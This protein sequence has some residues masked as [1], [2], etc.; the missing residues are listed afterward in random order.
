MVAEE[1]LPLPARD[2]FPVLAPAYYWA[3][4]GSARIH[5]LK[6]F[7]LRVDEDE[8]LAA[9]HE[10]RLRWLASAGVNLLFLSY[11]WGLPPELERRD[12]LDFE[13]AAARA[14]RL[15]LEVAAYVQPS[16]AADV[17]SYASSGWWALTP[18]GQRIPYYN[19]RYF[20]CLSNP[21]WRQTV[22]ERA[23]DAVFRGADAVF[24]DNC[25]FGG[26][27]IPL[28]ADTTG[29]A[30]CACLRCQAAFK[31]WLSREGLPASSI[32]RVLRAAANPAV[33]HYFRWRA[34]VVTSLLRETRQAVHA[35]RP[36]AVV[37]TNTFGAASVDAFAMFGV[38]M[39]SVAREVDWLFVENLQ[40]PR[41][42]AGRLTQNAGTFK[43]L[44]ALK[45]SAPALS[46]SYERG[47]GVDPVPPPRAF[48]RIAAE[49]FAAG[50][51]PVLRAGEYVTAGAWTHLRPVHHD[52]QLR[53]WRSMTDFV[54]ANPALFANRR[55]AAG[56][57]LVLPA[58]AQLARG[59]VAEVMA[60]AEALVAA[61][62]PFRVVQDGQRLDGV[63]VA[64]GPTGGRPPGWDGEWLAYAQL[65]PPRASAP[66]ERLLAFVEP[67]LRRVGPALLRAYY[68]QRLVRKAADR[69]D[70]LVRVA[71]VGQSRV[72]PLPLPMRRRLRAA[73]PVRA[74][75]DSPVYADLWQCPA[76]LALHLVNY[77]D[78]PARVR[79]AQPRLDAARLLTPRG[80]A[81][82]LRSGVVTLDRY[83]VLAWA[84]SVGSCPPREV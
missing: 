37:L 66:N 23:V 42:S 14:H 81:S 8:Y 76:G 27:P 38:D 57:A 67:L 82:V 2:E 49:A 60:V 47:T 59:G 22:R 28:G 39:V 19:G 12:W 84:A 18:E 41:V 7:T 24:L 1:R 43:V 83:A 55:S 64:V 11:N 62:I 52:E 29:F 48:A 5:R 69:L 51:T 79:V 32:P 15:G 36:S 3:G 80:D 26:M 54:S 77:G 25:C 40:S 34:G 73:S 13:V 20:T 56:L 61:T 71:A 44:R 31:D 33:E 63:T 45:P 74:V 9:Y 46:I 58:D 53:A 72:V 70:A 6:G 68:Q 10:D 17:G 65:V 78:Q 16:N 30:G 21:A 50:G 75:A 35:A 4:A